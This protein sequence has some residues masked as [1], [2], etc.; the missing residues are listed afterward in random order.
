MGDMVPADCLIIEA[1]DLQVDEPAIEEGGKFIKAT[2][3]LNKNEE[4]PEL[5]AGSIIRKG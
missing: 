3:E 1:Q 4:S 5:L 2:T